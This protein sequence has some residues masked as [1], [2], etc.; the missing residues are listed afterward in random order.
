MAKRNKYKSL[1]SV[2]YSSHSH[3]RR[4]SRGLKIVDRVLYVLSV[5]GAIAL[6]LA[7][8]SPHVNPEVSVIFSIF[9]L[10]A[11]L[12]YLLCVVLLV[13]WAIRLRAWLFVVLVPVVWGT[14]YMGR[15][16]Q[17]DWVIEHETKSRNERLTVLSYN[18]HNMGKLSAGGDVFDSILLH[19][20]GSNADVLFLQEFVLIDSSELRRVQSLLYE[21]PYS[22]HPHDTRKGLWAYSGKAIYSKFPLHQSVF[23][24]FNIANP[25][26]F[27]STQL[28]T[29]KDTITLINCHLQTTGVNTIT[30]SRG[31]RTM[32]SD[33]GFVDAS[34]QILN[35]L[36][37]NFKTRAPQAD[38]LAKII[39]QSIHPTIV[40]G[41]FNSVPMSYA[42]STVKGAGQRGMVDAFTKSKE[43]YGKTFAPFLGM[44]R[45]DYLFSSRD[46]IECIDYKRLEWHASDHLPIKATF[47][48]IDN[49]NIE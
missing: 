47:E 10:G 5:A 39:S 22:A 18:T 21:Y 11:P 49:N 23:H 31:V 26:G 32:I 24:T 30:N 4:K 41:D 33:S 15:Y 36:I 38:S 37:L 14:F 1:Q 27:I 40:G 43:G 8:I 45:I 44:L 17:I 42:Y 7:L 2:S 3:R 20:A 16:V 12:S 13:V 6:V 34:E 46:E 35:R 19:L 25:T 48:I 29:P 28:I 9:A